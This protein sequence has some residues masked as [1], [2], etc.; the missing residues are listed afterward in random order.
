MLQISRSA[1]YP[2]KKAIKN[3][4][5][6]NAKVGRPISGFSYGINNCVVDDSVIE[7]LLHEACERTPFY[8]YK[9]ITKIL[10]R[11]HG[12]HINDK[13]VY[14]LVKHTK[15]GHIAMARNIKVINQLW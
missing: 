6:E 13:K 5:D 1:Y 15:Q 14:R 3:H 8:G 11:N 4:S 9:K 7:T 2:K 10:R 12:L